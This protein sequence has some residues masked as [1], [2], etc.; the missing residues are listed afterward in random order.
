MNDA[1]PPEIGQSFAAPGIRDRLG[2]LAS[3][4]VY[5]EVVGSTNDLA[6]E[7]VTLDAGDGTIVVASEQSAGRGRLGRAWFSPRGGLYMSVVLQKTTSPTVT[8]L[9]GVAAAEGVRAATGVPVDLEWPNDLVAPATHASSTSP[10]AK[11]L[12]GVL[13]EATANDLVVV[14]IG[15]NL[16]RSVYPSEIAGRASC[17][18][19]EY[20]GRAK[21][22]EVLVEV[23][24]S[25]ELWRQRV[26]TS[27]PQAMFARWRELS[28]SC[29][30]T[31]VAW[32]SPDGRRSGV[33]AGI[34]SNGALRVRCDGRIERIIAGTLDWHMEPSTSTIS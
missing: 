9:A 3:V 15:V 28:P 24:A 4:L 20:D 33:T 26:R 23:L 12:G 13:C 32:D 34:D 17:V 27:G 7:L 21:R 2:T 6:M 11:K 16:S 18:D 19:A 8:L 1:I 5:R 14:G 25:L 22:G 31:T 10:R 30:G 29:D